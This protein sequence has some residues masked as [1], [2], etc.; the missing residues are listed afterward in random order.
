MY[1]RGRIVDVSRPKNWNI[2][3]L[4][5]QSYVVIAIPRLQISGS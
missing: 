2:I 4:L 3:S 1:T 5:N